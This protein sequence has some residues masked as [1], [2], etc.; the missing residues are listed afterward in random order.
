[1]FD[2]YFEQVWKGYQALTCSSIQCWYQKKVTW[3]QQAPKIRPVN[4]VNEEWC[5]KNLSTRRFGT[6]SKQNSLAKSLNEGWRIDERVTIFDEAAFFCFDQTTRTKRATARGQ[7]CCEQW[8]VNIKIIRSSTISTNKENKLLSWDH[9]FALFTWKQH[10][11]VYFLS[12]RAHKNNSL[13]EQRGTHQR[14]N[15][16]FLLPFPVAS[17]LWFVVSGQR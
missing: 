12:A 9:L 2:T 13:K 10:V 16:E 4:G 1:M 11:R 14:D 15:H 5:A 8:A 3:N 17:L 6:S 7:P